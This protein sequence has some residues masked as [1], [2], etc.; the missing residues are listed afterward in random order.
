MGSTANV[1]FG[2][3]KGPLTRPFVLSA[4][5]IIVPRACFHTLK[6]Y[7]SE[8]P[9]SE[10]LLSDVPMGPFTPGGLVCS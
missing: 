4:R 10:E 5:E 8:L 3:K 7:L 1:I 2:A 9:L 6:N